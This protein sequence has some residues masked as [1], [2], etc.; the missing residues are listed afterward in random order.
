MCKTYEV[1]TSLGVKFISPVKDLGY[2]YGYSKRAKSRLGVCK[3]HSRRI[4]LSYYLVTLNSDK[5]DVI[6]DTILHE[7]AHAIAY[8]LYGRNGGLDHGPKWVNI[9][10]QIGCDGERLHDNDSNPLNTP[11]GKYTLKCN[12]CGNSR[13]LH[14]K[15]K[16][17]IKSCGKCYPKGFNEKYLL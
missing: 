13:E 4:E 2:T 5:I 15:P 17:T 9:A 10:K 6:K 7:I 16:R 11:K 8:S 3:F 14:R 12:S 1:K